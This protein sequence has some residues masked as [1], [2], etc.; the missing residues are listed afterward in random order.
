MPI[1]LVFFLMAYTP[2]VRPLFSFFFFEFISV[3]I[4]KFLYYGPKHKEER[5]TVAACNIG[6]VQAVVSN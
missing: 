3:D 1:I 4:G 2:F 5:N 6:H